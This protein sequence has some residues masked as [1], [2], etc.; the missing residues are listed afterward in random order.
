MSTKLLLNFKDETY[1]KLIVSYVGGRPHSQTLTR[2]TLINLMI[3][4]QFQN[5]QIILR[6]KNS[7]SYSIKDLFDNGIKVIKKPFREILDLT[8][9]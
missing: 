2:A 8:S 6:S 4:N 9:D 7:T 3:E 1:D 5:N